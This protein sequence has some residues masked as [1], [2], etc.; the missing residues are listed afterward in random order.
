MIF[1]TRSGLFSVFLCVFAI[2]LLN[3]R[4]FCYGSVALIQREIL[5]IDLA[6]QLHVLWRR[7]NLQVKELF[8]VL[9][10]RRQSV[11]QSKNDRVAKQHGRLAYGLR[12]MR[13][14]KK[15]IKVGWYEHFGLEDCLP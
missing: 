11:S 13:T 14:I 7:G 15:S 1:V 6:R 9:F 3:Q 5:G 12:S 10:D 8:L 4:V 2:A